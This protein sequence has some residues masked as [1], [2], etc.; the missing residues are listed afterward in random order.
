[1]LITFRGEQYHW[2]KL[3]T[4]ISSSP[5][6]QM[7]PDEILRNLHEE[8]I[9]YGKCD[10]ETGIYPAV[11]KHEGQFVILRGQ[12]AI[13]KA[14]ADAKA[15]IAV[16]LVPKYPF[17]RTKHIVVENQHSTTS[18]PSTP[19]NRSSYYARKNVTESKSGSRNFVGRK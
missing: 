19:T 17:T 6:V 13:E 3:E 18:V 8:T 2:T 1:M 9:D 15:T 5:K 16:F 7:S 11:I 12:K 10:S 4:A 14:Q